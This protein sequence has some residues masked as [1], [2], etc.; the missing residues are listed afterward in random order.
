MN[1]TAMTIVVTIVVGLAFGI[2]GFLLGRRAPRQAWHEERENIK[3]QVTALAH[4][5]KE[6]ENIVR[7]SR[8]AARDKRE[9]RRMEHGLPPKSTRGLLAYPDPVV[10]FRRGYDPVTKQ[11]FRITPQGGPSQKLGNAAPKTAPAKKK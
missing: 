9:Q 7:T 4:E 8:M 1:N 5:A 6:L 10:P 11:F 2:G 3:Q